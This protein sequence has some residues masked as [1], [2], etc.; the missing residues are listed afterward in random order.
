MYV[1]VCSSCPI[2]WISACFCC[3]L[4]VVPVTQLEFSGI[5]MRVAFNCPCLTCRSVSSSS[6]TVFMT[7]C[8]LVFFALDVLVSRIVFVDDS[9]GTCNICCLIVF[10]FLID[11][12]I[13]IFNESHDYYSTVLVLDLSLFLAFSMFILFINVPL[14]LFLIPLPPWPSSAFIHRVYPCYFELGSPAERGCVVIELPI[15]F[16]VSALHS[17]K[18]W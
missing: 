2:L 1:W 11:F 12:V 14:P 16:S 4:I 6:Y 7:W 10:S 17:V 3:C 18:L 8:V 5:V 15:L 13:F 9:S